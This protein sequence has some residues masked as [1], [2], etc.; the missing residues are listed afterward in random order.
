MHE[1]ERT[2]RDI[3]LL[4]PGALG[5]VL[6]ARGVIRFFRETF[7]RAR[8]TLVAPGERGRFFRRDGWADAV[9]DWDRAPFSWLFSDGR[10]EPSPELRAVFSGADVVA[11]YLEPP[12]SAGGPPVAANLA[13]LA[14]SARILL[15]PA[16]PEPSSGMP[17]GRWLVESAARFCVDASLVDASDIHGENYSG[18]RIRLPARPPEGVRFGRYLAMH[19]GSG[20]TAKNWPVAHFAA[21]ARRLLSVYSPSGVPLFEGLVATS[22]EADGD[23]GERLAAAV[24]GSVL[25]NGATLEVVAVV[26]AGA[27]LYVGNDSGVS[28]LAAAVEDTTGK[29]PAVVAVFGRTDARIWAPPGALVAQASGELDTLSPE[30]VFQQILARGALRM[31]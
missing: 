24:P 10:G 29:S 9:F 22:G 21:L 8:L 14:P 25:V 7:P 28:H 4:R 19:P 23:L 30:A 18:S 17:I 2:V 11:A 15:R 26:L 6:A 13:A 27:A 5:D 31:A 3:V 12:T 20:G 16:R 1:T